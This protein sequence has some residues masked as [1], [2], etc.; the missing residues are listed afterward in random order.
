MYLIS[1]VVSVMTMFKLIRRNHDL[2]ELINYVKVVSA[3]FRIWL[4]VMIAA[5]L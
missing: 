3:G 2:D 1:C 4:I 5:Q